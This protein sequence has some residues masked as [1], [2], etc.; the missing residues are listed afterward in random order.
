M[1][2]MV[3]WEQMRKHADIISSLH[4]DLDDIQGVYRKKQSEV[5]LFYVDSVELPLKLIF[6]RYHSCPLYYSDT[7]FISFAVEAKASGPPHVL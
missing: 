3:Y 5:S 7:T 6:R 4:V 1:F 2:S